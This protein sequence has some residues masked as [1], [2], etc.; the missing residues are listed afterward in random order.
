MLEH[1]ELF[2]KSIFIDNMVF[3]TFLGM[4]S[5]LAVSKKVSTAVG[6]GAAVIFVLAVTV[7]MNWLL[8]KYL[9][10]DGALAWMG[11]E[12]ADYDLSFL[13][14]IL[15]IATIATMVQLVEIVV[16]KFSPSL[17]NSLGIF[18]PLIAVN[19]AILGGSLFMQTRDIPNIGLAFNYGISSGIGWFL[20]ILAIAAIREKIRY[21]NVPAP[22]RGLGITFI[23]TGL[24]GIGFQ[25]FGGMLTGDNEPPEEAQTTTVKAEKEKEKEIKKE[26]EDKE[27]AVSYNEAINK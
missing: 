3:A 4:C 26:I 8:D 11:P 14:F 2:F 6:L 5:Y 10:K 12:Y 16:E 22:L 15:F 1:L 17:Y 9:L 20:A 27:K 13:S 19:C 18:L 7:P 25:S 24:M 21:S 23:I